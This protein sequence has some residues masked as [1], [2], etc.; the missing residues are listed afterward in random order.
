M[1]DKFFR[2]NGVERVNVNSDQNDVKEGIKVTCLRIEQED[3]ISNDK[4]ATE[5]LSNM[6]YGVLPYGYT[7]NISIEEKCLLSKPA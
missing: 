5:I 3:T 4:Q 7:L 6:I 2:D 1:F